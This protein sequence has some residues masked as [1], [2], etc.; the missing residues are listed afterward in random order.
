MT[1]GNQWRTVALIC[2]CLLSNPGW[3]DEEYIMPQLL[4]IEQIRQ[5]EWL[6]EQSEVARIYIFLAV[7]QGNAYQIYAAR[8]DS[9]EDRDGAS[10][11]D[12]MNDLSEYESL[13]GSLSEPFAIDGETYNS[14]IS[15][16][17]QFGELFPGADD[18]LG[19]SSMINIRTEPAATDGS[20]LAGVKSAP[21]LGGD[22]EIEGV[23]RFISFYNKKGGGGD[24]NDLVTSFGFIEVKMLEN[25]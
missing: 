21:I 15:D 7:L 5:E 10:A 1:N 14:Y 11:S 13:G 16:L 8:G 12:E 6:S 23:H 20:R 3:T 24:D 2:L 25:K 19:G 22:G 17:P 9:D 4:D 18:P